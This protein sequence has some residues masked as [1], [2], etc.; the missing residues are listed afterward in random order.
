M[1]EKDV[2]NNFYPTNAKKCRYHLRKYTEDKKLKNDVYFK[3]GLFVGI[4]F[5]LVLLILIIRYEGLLDTDSKSGVFAKLFPCFR[6]LALLLIY[7]WY[8]SLDL[9][10]WNYFRINYKIY[11]GFNHHF[12]TVPEVLKRVSWFT[13][14]FLILFV[15]YILQTEM[16]FNILI[17]TELLPIILWGVFFIYIFTP[18]KTEWNGAGR[19]WMYRMLYGAWIGH[20]FKYESRYTFFLD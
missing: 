8:I 3:F 10:G 2:I 16:I 7:Y 17:P 20:F 9:V 15:L 6:G 11:L 4:A 19:R 13:A 1:I 12:S 18:T 5:C 14:F